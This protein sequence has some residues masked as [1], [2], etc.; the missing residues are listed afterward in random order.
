MKEW[1]I[2]QQVTTGSGHDKTEQKSRTIHKYVADY[3]TCFESMYF[4][5]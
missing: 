1:C 2:T 5:K 3:Q 4:Y